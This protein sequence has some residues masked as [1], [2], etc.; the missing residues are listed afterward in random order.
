MTFEIL[1]AAV[2]P[3]ISWEDSIA[4]FDLGPPAGRGIECVE[5]PGV[6]RE[7]GRAKNRRSGDARG[8]VVRQLP[9]SARSEK[10]LQIHIVQLVRRGGDG[11]HRRATTRTTVK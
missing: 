4:I 9:G 7:I 3:P 11:W 8:Q 1:V 6:R 5:F 10:S 2:A